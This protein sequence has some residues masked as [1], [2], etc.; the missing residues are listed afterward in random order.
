MRHNEHSR[1][2][3][4]EVAQWPGVTLRFGNRRKHR[5]AVLMYQDRERFVMYCSSPSDSRRGMKIKIAEV[6]RVLKELG[7]QKDG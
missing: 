7:A 1:A 3:E 6:R 5:E 4:R 2:I